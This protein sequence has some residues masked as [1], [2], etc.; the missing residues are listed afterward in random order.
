MPQ[1]TPEQSPKKEENP[2]NPIPIPSDLVVE[3]DWGVDASE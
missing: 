2:F 1:E 3:G